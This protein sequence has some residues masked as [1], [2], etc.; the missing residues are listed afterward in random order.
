MPALVGL[1]ARARLAFPVG[2]CF[3]GASTADY[4]KIY[5]NARLGKAPAC[6]VTS[7]KDML[8]PESEEQI[9]AILGDMVDEAIRTV[10]SKDFDDV[11]VIE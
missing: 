9:E 5:M 4:T 8:E 7:L 11:V 3:F 2:L 6:E 1:G 10:E